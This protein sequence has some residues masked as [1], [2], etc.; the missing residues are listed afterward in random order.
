MSELL[1]LRP[2]LYSMNPSRLNLF[3]KKFTRDLVVP[4]ISA[5]VACG[6]SEMRWAHP[7]AVKVKLATKNEV[8]KN[9]MRIE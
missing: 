2:P 4:T 3:M 5:S 9:E 6:G 7:D 1:I 8:V